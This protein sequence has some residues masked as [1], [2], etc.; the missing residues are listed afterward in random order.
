MGKLIVLNLHRKTGKE[1]TMDLENYRVRLQVQTAFGVQRRYVL[2]WM[3]V[4]KGCEK[5]YAK[6]D[7]YQEHQAG[8]HTMVVIYKWW[9]SLMGRNELMLIAQA[10]AHGS[11]IVREQDRRITIAD[12]VNEEG[13]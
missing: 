8:L 3:G 6:N 7:D 10:V 13:L 4:C 1:K 2:T 11:K 12:I 9:H 5:K